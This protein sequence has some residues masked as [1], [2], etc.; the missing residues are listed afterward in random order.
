[1]L[2]ELNQGFVVSGVSNNFYNVDECLLSRKSFIPHGR[3]SVIN[4]LTELGEIRNYW[5]SVRVNPNRT[6]PYFVEYK[7]LDEREL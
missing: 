6:I 1:M 4:N 2:R 3:E 5:E 7:K